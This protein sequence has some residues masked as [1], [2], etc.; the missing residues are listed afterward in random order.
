MID[1]AID[2]SA[3]EHPDRASLPMSSDAVNYRSV[4]RSMNLWSP[5]D[6][7]TWRGGAISLYICAGLHFRWFLETVFS[8]ATPLLFY[9]PGYQNIN[10]SITV[11][12]SFCIWF[13]FTFGI[14]STNQQRPAFFLL[15]IIHQGIYIKQGI[16]YKLSNSTNQN[17]IIY[18]SSFK[19]WNISIW[20]I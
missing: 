20:K 16:Y 17:L 11:S 13:S 1:T 8:S 18:F 14:W 6:E 9:C 15:G 10:S 3:N 19:T 7:L 4:S 12:Q 2:Y 5:D